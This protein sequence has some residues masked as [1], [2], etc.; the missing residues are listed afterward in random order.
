ML[1]HAS[2]GHCRRQ[3]G[4]ESVVA[5]DQSRGLG[6]ALVQGPRL[7]H[8]A[9]VCAHLSMNMLRV[10]ICGM[11]SGARPPRGLGPAGPPGLSLA[12]EEGGQPRLH[13]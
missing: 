6:I 12:R 8:E 11:S 5:G 4:W 3:T 7:R 9:N 13:H 10:E 2:G 1:T